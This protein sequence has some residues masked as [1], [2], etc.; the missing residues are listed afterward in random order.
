MQITP[1]MLQASLVPRSRF[2]SLAVIATESWAGP[3][4]EA[5]AGIRVASFPDPYTAAEEPENEA[6]MM[7]VE[8]N[9]R[10][11]I[12]PSLKI[13]LNSTQSLEKIC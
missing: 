4:N 11:T 1:T 5:I 9:T 2:S 7:F 3:G 8:G 10:C 12:F 6:A 13:N